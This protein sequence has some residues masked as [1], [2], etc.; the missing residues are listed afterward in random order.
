MKLQDILLIG[1]GAYLLSQYAAGYAAKNFAV[2]SAK[3]RI[4]AI[5]PTGLEGQVIMSVENST[6]AAV[7]IQSI[8]GEILYSGTAIAN[9]VV[10]EP[11]RLD[12]NAVTQL[13]PISFSVPFTGLSR[14]VIDA[15]ATGNW[16]TYATVRGIAR[17]A[18]VNIPFSYPLSPF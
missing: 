9:F 13:P 15:I 7:P 16:A 6:P 8:M 4:G 18:G 3:L 10:P 12:S 2:R 5:T 17:A 14:A 11:F 1:A